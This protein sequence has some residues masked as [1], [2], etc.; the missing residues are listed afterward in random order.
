MDCLD[1]YNSNQCDEAWRI[2]KEAY[3]S[4]ERAMTERICEAFAIR[5]T[6][7]L[8]TL[9]DRL[10]RF[11]YEFANP[12]QALVLADDEGR[13][14]LEEIANR[15]GKIPPVVNALYHHLK[16]VD[17]SQALAQLRAGS[18]H[19][20]AGLGW[21]SRLSLISPDELEDN[22]RMLAEE[23]GYELEEEK[24]FFL[25]FGSVDSNSD[26]VGVE[27]PCDEFDPIVSADGDHTV[28]SFYRECFR[29]GGF[30]AYRAYPDGK[31]RVPE[32]Y[33]TPDLE[34]YLP[35]LRHGLLPI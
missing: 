19:P 4:G 8:R 20:L 33:G 27:I 22:W 23:D 17:F 25:W 13:S 26:P 34:Q 11:G 31:H 18:S 21:H 14:R 9:H 7:N 6:A 1:K 10:V 24:N 2:A 32:L 12:N 28:R 29:W 35:Q 15:F 30:P 5:V 3:D 16:S